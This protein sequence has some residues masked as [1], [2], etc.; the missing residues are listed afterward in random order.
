MLSLQDPTGRG[1]SYLRL[2]V[3]DLC[4]LRC[5]YCLPNGYQ[6]SDATSHPLEIP[7]IRRLITAVSE[8]GIWK[9]RIT[10]GEPL[11]R[12]DITQIAETV[13]SC[14]GV[15]RLALSTNG[16]RFTR[17]A[18]DLLTA[19]VQAVNISVDSLD[20]ET[21][22]EVTGRDKLKEV[23]ESVDT[24]LELGF[25]SVKVNTV[26]LRDVNDKDIDKLIEWTRSIPIGVR[27]IELMRTNDNV[28]CFRKHHFSASTL[29]DKLIRG[30]WT[31][32]T[33]DKRLSA[34]WEHTLA[35][36]SNGVE[37]LTARNEESF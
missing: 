18:K 27:F 5:K 2:S 21:F 9:V 11:L 1:F 37:V 16:Y 15:K 28:D 25:S 6:K 34:Q 17:T 29:R 3:T 4:N 19:G 23:L 8:L 26:L 12:N 20:R 7:E 36:T 33:R 14:P 10:G 31:V 22:K 24:A 35:V 32:E 13:S 30:G